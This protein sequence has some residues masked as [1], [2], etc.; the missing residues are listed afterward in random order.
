MSHKARDKRKQIVVAQKA[1]DTEAW[2]AKIPGFLV[3][4]VLMLV[5][6]HAFLTVWTSTILGHYTLL[7]LWPEC[8]M[9][10]LSVWFF[11]SGR[12]AQTWRSLGRFRLG[13]PILLYLFLLILY[14][15]VTLARGKIGLQ[16][17]SYG[18]LLS[19]RPVVWFVL[20][21]A[22][23]EQTQWL[24][25]HWRRLTI[26]AVLL[27]AVFALLQ[28]FVLPADFLRHFGYVRDV[29]IAPVQTI[30]QDTA[31]IRAQ[32]TLRGPNPLGAYVALG[33]VLVY[34]A[35][36]SRLRKWVGIVVLLGALFVSFSRSAWLG[37]VVAGVAWIA[38]TH[39]LFRGRRQL[40]A[41]LAGML[42]VLVALLG[43]LQV[44]QGAKNALLHVNDQSTAPQT[45]NEG[46][47]E[48]LQKA[49]SDVLHEPLGRGPGTA[50]LASVYVRTGEPR[51]SEN[52]FLGVGQEYGWLGLGLFVAICYRLAL[53]L[54]RQKDT[55]SRA[56]FAAFMGLT[57]INLLSYAWSD[58]TLVYLWWGLAAVA[59]A[60]LTSAH[61]ARTTKR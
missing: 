15:A 16:A 9:L 27:V 14:F 33:I 37:T 2:A 43:L 55:L 44:N 10:L 42:L 7:R 17:A 18:L 31:T 32:S 40:F 29:T 59:L 45:S 58:V 8:M 19:A 21:Y 28:F 12:L 6:F 20:V 56:L 57:F 23:A 26:P 4:A 39:G 47:L 3:A 36:V 11:A 60:T 24:R 22:V 48:A 54:Y 50:G 49:S 30:N 61:A 52:F 1:G 41:A 46:R 51:Y 5:P 35:T 13:W 53:V 25:R 34:A 38:V